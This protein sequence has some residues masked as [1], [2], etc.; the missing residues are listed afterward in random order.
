M[1]PSLKPDL[2]TSLCYWHGFVII[3][4][5]YLL[6][7]NYWQSDLFDLYYQAAKNTEKRKKGK[8]TKKLK[9]NVDS[10]GHQS[11]KIILPWNIKADRQ[12]DNMWISDERTGNQI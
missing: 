10:K 1:I 2:P 9:Q 11:A 3:I 8:K 7:L 5:I 6:L 4:T 12:R